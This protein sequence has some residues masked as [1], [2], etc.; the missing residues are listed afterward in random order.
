MTGDVVP[1]YP[2]YVP[3]VVLIHR[4]SKVYDCALGEQLV[5][6]GGDRLCNF[7]LSF[8]QIVVDLSCVTRDIII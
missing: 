2:M 6:Q 1:V 3:H 5:H 7:I 8:S 4:A